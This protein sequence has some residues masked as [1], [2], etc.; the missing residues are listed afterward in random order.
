MTARRGRVLMVGMFAVALTSSAA[1][2][3]LN[4]TAICESAGGTYA[5]GTCTRWGPSQ[6]AARER[7]GTY[8][9]VYLVGE[10]IC[11]LGSGGP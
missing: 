4:V 1:G 7:C 6:Q 11:V 5:G 8:G 9:G 2:C 10:G 3:G